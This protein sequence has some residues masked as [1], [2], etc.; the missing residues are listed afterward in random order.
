MMLLAQPSLPT[1]ASIIVCISV[2]TMYLQ[3]FSAI[4]WCC[5]WD[6]L[7]KIQPPSLN[8]TSVSSI[9]LTWMFLKF[10]TSSDTSDQTLANLSLVANA[11]STKIFL[12][13][14]L[15]HDCRYKYILVNKISRP[16]VWGF[17]VFGQTHEYYQSMNFHISS[18]APYHFCLCCF[19]FLCAW[20]TWTL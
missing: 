5:T 17:R 2:G 4:F 14:V 8:R 1:V 3:E 12:E 10:C 18:F 19:T 16:V 11:L 13:S 7:L 20:M 6:V 9:T 15:A